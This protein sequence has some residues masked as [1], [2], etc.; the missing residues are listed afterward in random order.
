[1]NLTA[2]IC[3][4]LMLVIL[5]GCG[6]AD[7]IEATKV[8]RVIDGDTIVI[9]NK[10]YPKGKSVRIIGINTP[11]RH[12]CGYEEAKKNMQDMVLAKRVTLVMEGNQN[13]DKWHR[14]LR[15]VDLGGKDVGKEQIKDG[16]AK[17]Q[18]DSRD[19]YPKHAREDA[20]HQE[21]EKSKD[22]CPS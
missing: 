9:V 8:T 20:Y 18:Y 21:D 7:A 5:T 4:A 22:L 1:M 17:A 14:L 13:E 2:R 11:E 12:E 3:A 6:N 16:L 15:Y 10:E 19:G